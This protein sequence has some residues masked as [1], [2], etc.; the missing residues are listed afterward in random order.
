MIMYQSRPLELSRTVRVLLADRPQFRH[1][2]HS[3]RQRLW[4]NLK[5]E[6]RT[7]RTPGTD[8]PPFTSCNPLETKTSLDKKRI[9]LRTVRAPRADRPQFTF[10]SPN[11][12]N[13]LS[14]TKLRLAGG[15]SAPHGRTVRRS[16]LKPT[17]DRHPFWYKFEIQW[18]TVRPLGPDCPP[19]H[20]SL[21]KL[22]GTVA[23]C[24]PPLAGLSAIPPE[25]LQALWNVCGLS[26]RQAR[27]VRPSGADCPPLL[28]QL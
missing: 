4:T 18:R 28:S 3:E 1:S 12:R 9:S 27:T 17:P 10:F 23:D 25:P 19:A 26:A 22:S 14:G 2:E 20:Q 21:C 15:P 24:P 7:V 8:R 11:Q 16:T 6:G 13:N 5:F